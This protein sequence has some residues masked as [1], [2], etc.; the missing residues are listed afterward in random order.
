MTT[1]TL[2]ARRLE[3]K[4]EHVVTAFD[5][6]E[7]AKCAKRGRHFNHYALSIYLGRVAE[8]VALVESGVS[9]HR[10]LYDNFQDTLLTALEKACALPVTYGGGAH[11]TGRPA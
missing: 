11:D 10:A 8:V 3:F 7:E 5:T 4:L 9:L 6:K 1:E 2:D